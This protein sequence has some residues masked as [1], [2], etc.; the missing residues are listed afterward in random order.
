MEFNEEELRRIRLHF[1][2]EYGASL[3]ELMYRTQFGE[4]ASDLPKETIQIARDLVWINSSGKM[5]DLGRLAADSCREYTFWLRRGKAL[6]FEGSGKHLTQSFFLDKSV[7]EVGCGMGANLMSLVGTARELSGV[8]PTSAYSQLG[9]IFRN[10]ESMPQLDIRT[11]VAETLPFENNRFD[12]VFCVAAHHYF[13]ICSAL[14]EFERVLKPGGQLLI[15]GDTLEIEAWLAVKD[16]WR[17]PQMF[18]PFVI[19]VINTM[20]YMALKRR[21]FRAKNNSTTSRAIFP[22]RSSMVR[23]LN[24][25]GLVLNLPVLRV[26]PDTCFHARKPDSKAGPVPPALCALWLGENLIPTSALVL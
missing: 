1:A 20:S 12:I 7:L 14:D 25:A 24:N 15:I 11:G 5:T 2:G 10:R 8:E 13:D 3:I 21:V 17:R 22:L 4:D 6:P 19:S 18:K 26:G 23:W 16:S 9:A